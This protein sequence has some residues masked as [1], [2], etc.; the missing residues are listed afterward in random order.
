MYTGFSYQRWIGIFFSVCCL[1]TTTAAIAIT[2]PDPG[3]VYSLSNSF[4][5]E[6]KVLGVANGKLVMDK[7]SQSSDNKNLLWKFTPVNGRPGYFRITNVELG[8]GKSLD[9]SPDAPRM[10]DS[11]N[12]SGQLW[13]LTDVGNGHVRLS[14][15]YQPAKSLDTYGNAPH[16]PFLGNTGNYSG[17]FWKLTPVIVVTT[18]GNNL[19]VKP[20]SQKS[21]QSNGNQTL[22]VT[23]HK[24]DTT[25][26]VELPKPGK[27]GGVF[28]KV[29][30]SRALC[31]L[32]GQKACGYE[33]AKFI[34][35]AVGDCP[36]GSFLDLTNWSCWSCPKGYERSAA[37]VSTDRACRKRDPNA[38][39]EL[40]AA[41]FQGRLCPSGS[42]FDPIRG[43]E[44][45]SCPAGYNRSAA[46]ITEK[47]ACYIPV[48]DD[49]KKAIRIKT[50][51]WP[52]ECRSGTFHDAIAGGCFSCPVGYKRTGHSVQSAKACS[53]FIAEQHKHAT[54]VK[55]A[56]CGP[57][58]IRDDRIK[59]TQDVAA[60][61]GCWTCPTAWDRTVHAID[62]QQAC[63]KDGGFVF[64]R[65]TEVGHLSCPKG[66]IFDLISSSDNNVKVFLNKR[67]SEL[68]DLG[69]K[70][71][72]KGNVA[73]CWQCPDTAERTG[74]AVYAEDAC[75]LNHLKWESAEYR[76]RG[77]FGLYGAEQVA[78]D[79]IRDGSLI[80]ETVDEMAK[81]IKNKSAAE[82]RREVWEE[83]ATAPQNSDVLNLTVFS[84]L[85]QAVENPNQ[86][87]AAEKQLVKS[88]EEAIRD[89][90]V[91]VAQD[92][93]DAY[94]AWSRARDE[95]KRRN[96]LNN[97]SSRFDTAF[98]L[99][100][101][102]APN[103]DEIISQSTLRAVS[104]GYAS[105]AGSLLLL[106]QKSVSTRLFPHRFREYYNFSN[107]LRTR[108]SNL[109]TRSSKGAIL[110]VDKAT[111]KMAVKV[112]TQAVKGA[113]K[114][115]AVAIGSAGPQVIIT[116]A[117][118][119]ISFIVE[120]IIDQE[121]ARPFLVAN[122]ATAKQPVDIK[123]M[124]TT[125]S[126][127]RQL[128]GEWTTIN[129][130]NTQPQYLAQFALLAKAK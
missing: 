99:D 42:F 106:D 51:V 49:L 52:H 44:C 4:L 100:L 34:D 111:Q 123:R 101:R 38:R 63:E 79:L 47:N 104:E 67:N 87:T 96:S 33:P 116:L 113:S 103:F 93:L 23:T 114:T 35:N 27:P 69:K 110:A 15:S 57:G 84:R 31:G 30:K 86:A 58:E 92:A 56:E 66:Q 121:N 55:K 115:L 125:G 9:S 71:I 68:R 85:V 11:G 40:G 7:K 41:T 83:I 118:E 61:G 21:T 64:A 130:A 60:G 78:L 88:T 19:N 32:P 124:N 20:P 24:I 43:G 91:F 54:V 128:L 119:A 25:I 8:N 90:R 75:R 14:N 73:T 37:G 1:L 6:D 98:E 76:Q 3:V 50:T 39:G 46:H 29:G 126:G 62:G 80:N 122:L 5:K 109:L 70:Q 105:M 72:N 102:L 10:A 89:F 65:A 18:P 36:K 12:Y 53:K 2:K 129:S 120:R 13:K 108:G 28:G 117:I 95:D 94:D 26:K 77:L 17:Q 59:G 107:A 81:E 82:F 127:A 74:S 112:S 16:A 22:T 97:A 48:H 45:Y